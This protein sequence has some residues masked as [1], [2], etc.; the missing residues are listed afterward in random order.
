M[1]LKKI[2]AKLKKHI[3]ENLQKKKNEIRFYNDTISV[4][5]NL[6]KKNYILS[7]VTSKDLKRTKNFLGKNFKLFKYI[8]CDDGKVRGKPFPDQVD[9]VINKLKARRSECI[10]IGDTNVDHVTAKNSN[11]DFIFALWGYGKKYNYKTKC[12]SIKE[13]PRVLKKF[14][15]I[16]K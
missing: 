15:N 5:N 9:I 14:E 12:K 8:Q 10:Y 7:I 4:L 11:I 16:S 2:L 6:K 13:L 1:V 3:K